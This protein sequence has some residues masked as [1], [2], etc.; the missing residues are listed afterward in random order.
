MM[1]IQRFAA[2]TGKFIELNNEIS[3]VAS[4]LVALTSTTDGI[5]FDCK[6]MLMID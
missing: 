2:A 6:N 5:V 4:D 3:A 1:K